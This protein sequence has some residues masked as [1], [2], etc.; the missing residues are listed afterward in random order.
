MSHL[1]ALVNLE[2][3]TREPTLSIF[4]LTRRRRRRSKMNVLHWHIVDIPSFPF[5][6]ERF[7]NLSKAGAFDPQHQYR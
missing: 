6:S 4:F 1:R 2:S 3:L 7:P 5:V